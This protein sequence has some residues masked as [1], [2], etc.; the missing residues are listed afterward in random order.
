MNLTSRLLFLCGML[1]ML[2]NCNACAGHQYPDQVP[3]MSDPAVVRLVKIVDGKEVGYCTAWKVDENH[4][5]TAGH[6]CEAP[7]DA[8]TLSYK[9]TGPHAVPGQEITVAF[10]NDE[11]D[12]C[13][14]KGKAYGAPIRLA[15]LDPGM[16][17]MVWTAGFPHLE[18]LI[19]AGYWSGR[20]ESGEYAK[21]SVAVFGGASGSPVLNSKGEAVGILVAYFPPMSNMALLTPLEWARDAL[22][23]RGK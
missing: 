18:Y 7:D 21:A 20:T 15:S 9:S 16:G 3:T 4:L 17:E 22:A 19:S 10:D 5:M 6:C 12:A 1:I 14:M 8:L 23:H 13:L 11:H 2:V